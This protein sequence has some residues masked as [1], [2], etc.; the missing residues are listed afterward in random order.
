[1][2][3]V[4][5][6]FAEP[7]GRYYVVLHQG[8]F[9]RLPRL[10]LTKSAWLLKT[11]Y[12]GDLDK[13]FVRKSQA[14]PAELQAV[15]QT[16]DLPTQLNSINANQ[17]LAW[18]QANSYAY[19]Q[20]SQ[21]SQNNPA[22]QNSTNHQ[23]TQPTTTP[24]DQKAPTPTNKPSGTNKPINQKQANHNQTNH[25]QIKQTAQSTTSTQKAT[26]VSTAPKSNSAST[27]A[28]NDNGDNDDF[29]V[30]DDLLEQLN[31]ELR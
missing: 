9:W 25:N 6:V 19:G 28:S 12:K 27:S 8:Q 11:P 20:N 26:A 13:I 17:F 14:I 23:S 18:W 3:F 15:L 16:I 24:K 5:V 4:D 2:R 7:T 22:N 31:S 1:M 29:A 10:S 30:F 21:N